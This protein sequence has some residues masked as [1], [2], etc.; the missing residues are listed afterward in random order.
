MLVHA[1]KR[2]AKMELD[3]DLMGDRRENAGEPQI[4]MLILLLYEER[5]E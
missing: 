5:E 4:L 3:I 1:F 2:D